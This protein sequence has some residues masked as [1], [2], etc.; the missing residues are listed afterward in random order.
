MIAS[1]KRSETMDKKVIENIFKASQKSLK[2][3]LNNYLQQIGRTTVCEDGFLYAKGTHPVLL[4]AHMDTVHKESPKTILYS[5]DGNTIM[6]LEGIGGD[7]RC[8]IIMILEIL[9]KYD[10]SVVFT[11]DEEI[12]CVG[13]KKFCES[14]IELGDVNYAVEF[15]RKGGNDYVFYKDYN[16]DFEE[17]IKKFGFVKATGS[18]S[19]ISH[20]ATSFKIEAV[21]ISCGYYCPHCW[22]EY[23]KLNEMLDIIDR[24]TKM[25]GEKTKKFD[26]VEP[27][28]Y[29][30]ESPKTVN[31]YGY[32]YYQSS[33]QDG[34]DGT[35][36]SWQK[37]ER[38]IW[39]TQEQ[40]ILI[41]GMKQE[42][43]T[44]IYMNN[45][46][47]IFKDRELKKQLKGA[48]LITPKYYYPATY[49]S[50]SRDYPDQLYS[51]EEESGNPVYID[52]GQASFW[53]G[54]EEVDFDRIFMDKNNVIYKDIWLTTPYDDTTLLVDD[55][56]Y[57]IEYKDFVKAYPE[58]TYL[59]GKRGNKK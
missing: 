2:E 21:N 42:P 58:Q 33:L 41:I 37:E 9:R 6:S 3:A 48:H 13:A 38:P 59:L 26:Y 53:V 54:C 25:I 7:D 44:K 23:V 16:E 24:A 20:I 43:F 36:R 56:F 17:H 4:V 18:C 27:T 29:K 50:V 31:N 40:A 55:S 19:D 8:G 22:Y 5:K 1:T 51:L 35:F 30:Y 57:P 49:W 46:G 12:G 52:R 45:K 14:G 34:Y 10:C 28:V 15:D 11:E 39:L 32:G 47:D